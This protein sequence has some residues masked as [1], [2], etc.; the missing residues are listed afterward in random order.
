MEGEKRMRLMKGTLNRVMLFALA[1]WMFF[2]ARMTI[3]AKAAEYGLWVGNTRITDDNKDSIPGIIGGTAKYDP[4]THTLTL[5]GNVTGIKG[6]Y[7]SC[8]IYYREYTMP[9]TIKGKASLKNDNGVIVASSGCGIILDG[10]FDFEGC[11]GNAAIIH[12]YGA[13]S[14]GGPSTDG[15]VQLR[16]KISVTGKDCNCIYNQLSGIRIEGD[17]KLVSTNCATIQM[18]RSGKLEI[19][20]GS[21]EA[22]SNTSLF[23]FWESSGISIADGLDIILPAEGKLSSNSKKVLTADGKEANH[24]KVGI[25]GYNLWV[26]DTQVTKHNKN[27]IPCSVG[28]ASYNPGT[29]TLTFNNATVRTGHIYRKV[30]DGGAHAGVY[31]IG[32]PLTIKGD[33]IIDPSYDSGC[34]DAIHVDGTEIAANKLVLD[35]NIKTRVYARGIVGKNTNII[36]AGGRLDIEVS[37]NRGG[38]LRADNSKTIELMNGMEVLSPS[39]AAFKRD[40]NNVTMLFAS[41]TSDPDGNAVQKAIIGKRIIRYTIFLDSNGGSGKS[42]FYYVNEGEDYILPE[43]E[44]TPPEGKVF[45]RWDKGPAGASVKVT[46]DITI[47]AIWK[48]KTESAEGSSKAPTVADPAAGT[49]KVGDISTDNGSSYEI[50]SVEDGK[51]TVKFLKAES[52]SASSV[53]I[54]ESITLGNKTFKV[55]EIAAGAFKGNKKLRSITIGKNIEKIG[56]KAFYKCKNLKNIKIKTILLTKNSV[57]GSAFKGIHPKAK[58]KVPKKKLKDYQKL[59][60]A[61][62][63]KEKTQKIT[64]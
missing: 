24:V 63:I 35:A 2:G 31:A 20:S 36:V 9:L 58:V 49:H 5:D 40:S 46:E 54:P 50:T 14:D 42:A 32:M 25:D 16:G 13:R 8:K 27:A 10:E 41:K 62:G 22:E 37:N 7:S 29:N 48:D 21:F 64:K 39:G 43:C 18:Y 61:K 12:S 17:V 57:G 47:K 56:S 60:K 55:T 30:A 26:G 4:E 44:F 19:L 52:D 6:E 53:A 11:A 51:E 28:T 3:T 38:V 34:T 33:V 23:Q 45:D 59:L 15:L 1:L